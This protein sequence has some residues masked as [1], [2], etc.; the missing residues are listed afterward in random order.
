MAA[1]RPIAPGLF[2]EDAD[3]PRLV[4][5]RCPACAR[6]QFPAAET[7]PYCAA[8]GCRPVPVGP[9]GTLCL[10]T[11]VTSRPPGYRGELP[12][13]FG[14]VELPEGLRVVT[15]LTEHRIERLRPGLPVRLVVAP[16]FT[17]DEGR[18]VLSWAFRP[19]EA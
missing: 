19:V 15:R 12:Y 2:T 4:A 18:G 9:A 3:E 5:A 16:L 6:L 7:C 11:A 17:D 8:D 13:G 1:T 14:V 10:Y